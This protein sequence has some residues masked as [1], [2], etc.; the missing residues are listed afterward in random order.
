VTS[1]NEQPLTAPHSGPGAQDS[2]LPGPTPVEV[3]PEEPARRIAIVGEIPFAGSR[4]ARALVRHGLAVGVL[5]PDSAAEQAVLRACAPGDA[6]SPHV[7]PQAR[8]E[9][10][11]GDLDSSAALAAVMHGADGACFISPVT[12]SGRAFRPWQ[13]LHDVQQFVE[14]AQAAGVRKVVYH[15]ALGAH[16][17]AASRTLRD[18]AAAEEAVKAGATNAKQ[19][20]KNSLF[21]YYLARSGLLM[22]P[23]DGFLSA[24]IR[25]AKTSSP[26]AGVLGY[27]STLVQPLHVDDFAECFARFFLERPEELEAGRYA[28]AGPEIRTLLQLQDMALLRLGRTKLKYHAPLFVLG[29]LAAL[30]PRRAPV[31][32]GKSEAV[33]LRER[34]SLLFDVFV[35]EHNDA[36]R[37]LG[38]GE[39]LFTLKQTQEEVLAAAIG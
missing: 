24:L 16:V 34:V 21:R 18:A 37:L 5:C 20:A 26:F 13:H 38:P 31:A 11:H 6:A 10:V 12:M 8:I 27:G 2:G 22:G 4:V 39:T 1:D 29:A 17:K 3:E 14:A 35:T 9:A 19:E 36:P 32:G 30:S 33:G 15:S 25:S 23:A 28:L 7:E